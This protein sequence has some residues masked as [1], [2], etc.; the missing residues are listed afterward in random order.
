MRV[1]RALP[2]VLL[3]ALAACSMVDMTP[4]AQDVRVA[5]SNE[6]LAACQRR[7]EIEVSVKDRLGPYERDALRVRDELEVLAR[8]EAEGL[9]A[10]TLQA[11]AAP[12]EGVQR[13]QAYRCGSARTAQPAAETPVK[14]AAQ[15]APLQD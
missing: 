4:A 10:D 1:Y 13:F 14:A 15:T 3:V 2:L 8:N 11:K 7:G 9:S 12:V 6:N 5:N